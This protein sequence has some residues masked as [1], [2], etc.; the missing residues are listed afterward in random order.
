VAILPPAPALFSVTT[1]WPSCSLSVLA[2]M[3]D[4]VSVPPPGAN[5]TTVVIARDG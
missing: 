1:C 5:P 4:T 3:R 2:M